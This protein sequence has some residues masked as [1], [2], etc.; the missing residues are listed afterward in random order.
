MKILLDTLHAK[1]VHSSLALPYLAST[2]ADL[3]GLD[4]EILELTVNEQQDQLLTRLH[5]A[6]ADAVLF[7]CY[8]WNTEL[9][10]KLA[11]DLKQLAP[12]TFIVLGGPEVS[13]GSFEMMV[14]NGAIDCIVRG[15][16]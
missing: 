9:T 15:E 7:S 11:S 14:R 4:F 12:D 3:A 5:G 10:L 16:G 2:C 6:A 1:Y 13:F 8:I